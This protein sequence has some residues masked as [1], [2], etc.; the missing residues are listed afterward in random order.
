[1]SHAGLVDGKVAVVTGV[2]PGLGRASA[3]ALAREGAAVVLVARNEDRLTAAAEEIT[4]AGGR[5]LAVAGN[6]TKPD[7][8]ERVAAAAVEHFGGID[9]VVNS[10]RIGVTRS[11]RSPMRTSTSGARSSRSTFSVPRT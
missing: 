4:S 11:R 7:D 8:C 2:G 1:M 5:A 10:A 6:V 9:V 3:L